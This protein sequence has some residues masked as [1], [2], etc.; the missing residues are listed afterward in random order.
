VPQTEPG[1]LLL[2]PAKNEEKRIEPV[3]REYAEYFR[4]NYAGKFSIVVVLNGC[5]D[6]TWGVVERVTRDY[7]SVTALEFPAPIGKGGALIEGFKL[8]DRA[9]LIGYVDADGATS[10]AA[11]HDL[12]RRWKE[13]DC[14]IASRWLPASVLHQ[15]QTKKR[16]FAS[17][18]FH[19]IV[20]TFFPSLNVRDTQCGAKI[21]RREAAQKIHPALR[22]ADM[23]FDINLLY[24]LRHNGFSV[25]E[26]PTEWTDKLGSTVVLGRTSLVMF[27]S[28]VR[29]RI[30]YSP[31]ANY[32]RFLRPIEKWIYMRLRAPVP[33]PRPDLPLSDR[34]PNRDRE[35]Q[36]AEHAES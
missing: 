1:V 31:F 28:V 18:V 13:A 10:P 7:Q 26:L 6:N 29:L 9:D 21:M 19:G 36:H 33:L 15:A 34:K 23:A 20:R 22:I 30:I 27:L 14:V 12:L 25:L 11:Y 35:H 4:R 17:R 2:I 16:Q 24:A 5:S 32:L 8:A 3:L